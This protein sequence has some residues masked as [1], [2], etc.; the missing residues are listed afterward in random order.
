MSKVSI[1]LPSYNHE[2]FLK[3]RL[4]SIQNQT[5][6]DWELIIID[7]C[8]T[9]ASAMIL[10]NFVKLNKSKVK[11]FI[12]ND[13][14]SGSGYVSWQKGIE[15]A[16][17]EYVWIAE[18]DDYCTANFLEETVKCLDANAE[19][20][21]VFVASNYVDVSR[22]FLYDSSNRTQLLLVNESD[23]GLFEN[24]IFV[25]R[26]PLNPLII[27]GSSVLFRKPK[28][29]VPH[30]I[31]VN[32]QMSDLFLW[33]FLLDNKKFIFLNKK[34][35]FFR[36]H[37]SSTTT[38]ANLKHKEELYSEYIVYA[39]YFNCCRKDIYLIIKK[40]VD[41]FLFT[42]HNKKGLLYFKTLKKIE[43]VNGVLLHWFLFKAFVITTLIRTNK[44]WCRFLGC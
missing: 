1:I 38:I 27:N 37:E 5:L 2:K 31:F 42:D 4:D 28:V 24:N 43:G 18:T 35:N 20:A 10:E 6:E 41:D 25:E 39:N 13:S 9:D 23:F 7:D 21:L 32:K 36:R 3:D 11:H 16:E 29:I 22:S 17:S 19:A 40:Y 8:S 15:F 12:V 14:N 33:R 34:L 26:L 30:E 44:K